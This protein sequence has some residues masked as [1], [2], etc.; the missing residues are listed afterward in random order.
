MSENGESTPLSREGIVRSHRYGPWILF[1]VAG[2]V[3]AQATDSGGHQ[4]DAGYADRMAAEHA[5]D[6]PVAT[7]D[8]RMGSPGGGTP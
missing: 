2:V 5:G 8:C 1:L 7:A 4:D 3:S 6:R